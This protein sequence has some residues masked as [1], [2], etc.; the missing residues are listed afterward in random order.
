MI[1][2]RTEPVKGR[3]LQ[4]GD[5][6]STLGPEYWDL[7]GQRDGVGERVYIRTNAPAGNFPDA[8]EYVYKITVE[9]SE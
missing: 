7:F 8:D 3:D 1:I 2:I 4:P 6:F 5:L 9:R